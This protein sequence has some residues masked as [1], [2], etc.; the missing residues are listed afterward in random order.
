MSRRIRRLRRSEGSRPTTAYLRGTLAPGARA[1]AAC[2]IVIPVTCAPPSKRG[3]LALR[4]DALYVE[5]KP[6]DPLPADAPEPFYR[7]PACPGI[8]DRTMP[9]QMDSISSARVEAYLAAERLAASRRVGVG[10]DRVESERAMLGVALMDLL[11]QVET[12]LRMEFD[13]GE[14]DGL[15]LAAVGKDGKRDRHGAI[16]GDG[17]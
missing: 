15:R 1:F 16:G 9:A 14:L 10:A 6:R 4:R 17:E 12:A 3:G 7:F 8:P 2:G 5:E 11:R 13:E